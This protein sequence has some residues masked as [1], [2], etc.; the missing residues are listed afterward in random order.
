MDTPVPSSVKDLMGLWPSL[1]EF[2][3]D[4]PAG[5]ETVRQWFKR[6]SI[7]VRYWPD[8]IAGASRRGLEGVTS[9]L[10]MKLHIRADER[11]SQPV[12]QAA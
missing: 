2:S 1:V 7:P 12:E 11:T 4:V 10:L 8:V 5:Y 3:A 6:Q 9:D